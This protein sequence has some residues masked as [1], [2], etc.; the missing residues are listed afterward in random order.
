MRSVQTLATRLSPARRDSALPVVTGALV[1]CLRAIWQAA[2]RHDAERR[3]IAHLRA[4]SDGQLRDLG[5]ARSDIPRVV[6]QPGR[7]GGQA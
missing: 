6:R 2:L 1:R 4:M 7:L 5:I 3:A